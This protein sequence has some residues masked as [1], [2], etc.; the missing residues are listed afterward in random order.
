MTCQC[1]RFCPLSPA[2]NEASAP[3]DAVDDGYAAPEQSNFG[4]DKSDVVDMVNG[5]QDADAE[6]DSF[7]ALHTPE[8]PS[9]EI[10]AHHNLTHFPYRVWCPYCY[11]ICRPN[12][13]HRCLGVLMLDAL[14][15]FFAPTIASSET[16]TTT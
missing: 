1:S 13:H 10:V 5:T 12:S 7:S 9:A 15:P 16:K 8:L 4:L 6:T 2:D 14:C 3:A 11:A